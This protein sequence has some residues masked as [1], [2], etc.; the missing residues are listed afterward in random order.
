MLSGTLSR[1]HFDSIRYGSGIRSFIQWE[2]APRDR[3]YHQHHWA[4]FSCLGKGFV[5]FKA[6]NVAL[7]TSERMFPDGPAD[8][9]NSYCL[10][11]HSAAMVLAQPAMTLSTWEAEVQKM[12]NA[13]RVPIPEE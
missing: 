2:Q 4:E 10:V 1:Q 5:G 6:V 3:S 9:V 12:R 11:R 8:V 13:Y 7:P